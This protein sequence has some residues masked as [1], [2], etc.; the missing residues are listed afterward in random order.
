MNNAVRSQPGLNTSCVESTE[1]DA[2][3]Y[4]A[5]PSCVAYNVTRFSIML[6]NVL[7]SMSVRTEEAQTAFATCVSD[8][9]YAS[10]PKYFVSSANESKADLEKTLLLNPC[11]GGGIWEQLFDLKQAEVKIIAYCCT[12]PEN[13]VL[14]PAFQT[15]TNAMNHDW[16]EEWEKFLMPSVVALSKSNAFDSDPIL[17]AHPDWRDQ[18]FWLQVMN[19]ISKT[20]SD[21]LFFCESQ[22]QFR[23]SRPPLPNHPNEHDEFLWYPEPF[24]G[25]E[26]YAN[27]KTILGNDTEI[28][29]NVL[30]NV[31]AFENAPATKM[32]PGTENKTDVESSAHVLTYLDSKPN[33][34]L[35]RGA[36][37]INCPLQWLVDMLFWMKELID[38]YY[39]T[40][41]GAIKQQMGYSSTFFDWP[42]TAEE[43]FTENWCAKSQA[44]FL[45]V[46]EGNF[47][48]I[49]MEMRQ[50]LQFV[51]ALIHAN[52]EAQAAAKQGEN[53]PDLS[54]AEVCRMFHELVTCPRLLAFFDMMKKVIRPL[55]D[56]RMYMY[57][58]NPECCYLPN[59]IRGN[60][61]LALDYFTLEVFATLA[62]TSTASLKQ[63]EIF[64][65]SL[66]VVS[67]VDRAGNNDKVKG[68]TQ[69]SFVPISMLLS[70]VTIIDDDYLNDRL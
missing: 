53:A 16:C 64:S 26:Y 44:A 34:G 49:Q 40:P 69:I 32:T 11:E 48:E 59:E 8:F 61:T 56:R 1:E 35:C 70:P 20:I 65:H 6:K 4:C 45:A 7:Y 47:S 38:Y 17:Q 55:V 63:A 9:F 42:C 57:Q 60:C 27:V 18:Y 14:Q 52:S 51:E 15:L 67:S 19:D 21:G 58:Q 28:L 43:S 46:S 30:S 5:A 66:L 41:A 13:D 25:P 50:L 54:V 33:Y 10:P 3:L 23:E 39:N 2:K 36:D 68:N 31:S 37:D 62:R 12:E 29:I 22:P 24:R